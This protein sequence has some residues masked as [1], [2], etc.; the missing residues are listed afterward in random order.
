MKILVVDDEKLIREKLVQLIEQSSLEFKTILQGASVDEAI[1]IIDEYNPEIVLTDINMPQKNGLE[2]AKYIYNNKLEC[3][4]I[5]ITGY[6][7]FEY[8]QTAI[9]Y[10]VFDYILKPIDAQFT[11][12]CVEKAKKKYIKEHRQQNMYKI[13][14]DYFV[15]NYNLLKKQFL[16][17][18]LFN[19]NIVDKSILTQQK[20][21]FEYNFD[22]YRLVI[23]Q[24]KSLS[25]NI[26]PE[27][28][29]YYSYIIE[30]YIKKYTINP[31][32]LTL[33][34]TVYYFMPIEED[35]EKSM[36]NKMFS[37]IKHFIE[38]TYPVNLL[39]GISSISES[40]MQVKVL[41]RQAYACIEYQE[42][43]INND[44]IYYDDI[45]EQINVYSDLEEYINQLNIHIQTGNL[46]RAL[47]C[48]N[49]IFENSTM[50]SAEQIK[51]IFQLIISNLMIFVGQIEDDNIRFTKTISEINENLKQINS[52]ENL[53]N[54]INQWIYNMC[55]MVNDS[56]N[57]KNNI[58]ISTIKEYIN[59]NFYKQISLTDVAEHV[60]RNSSYIS[61]L[62]KQYTNKNFTQ[63]LTEKRIV[64]AKRLLKETTLKVSDISEKVGY[65]NM[66]Y[67]NRI[68]NANVG[69]SANDYRKIV[70]TLIDDD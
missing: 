46:K 26:L 67:F 10:N 15:Q 34:D 22:L 24:S 2:I 19:H 1:S 25:N 41:K 56:V 63:L 68:F 3:V 61:R 20:E 69:M 17:N 66:R 27:E 29:Y 60:S 21:I 58:L 51:S 57:N 55:S 28:S 14:K 48:V 36:Y 7:E 4:V 12:D 49:I 38:K 39:I 9:K 44:F 33:G 31:I 30:K 45:S 59:Q 53:L 50:Y 43:N 64:E 52:K 8:A 47:N 62:I 23:F 5:L 16:E 65:P 6:A 54:F 13:F 42:N 70:C 35:N 18:I 40:L 37:Q 32:T 11:L